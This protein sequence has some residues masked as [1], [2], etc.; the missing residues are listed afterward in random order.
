MALTCTAE[1]ASSTELRHLLPL[2]Q[3]AHLQLRQQQARPRRARASDFQA[4]RKLNP[5]G[6]RQSLDGS[7]GAMKDRPGSEHHQA[8][9]AMQ[10]PEGPPAQSATT[11]EIEDLERGHL[12][13]E[14]LQLHRLQPE[15]PRPIETIHM[16]TPRWA[17]LLFPRR[18]LVPCA[19]VHLSPWRHFPRRK[20]L[21]TSDL[22]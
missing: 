12:L 21:H 14:G 6:T 13:K 17:S 15:N 2:A 1:L 5:S 18:S 10:M 19:K 16:A 20:C 22:T 8:I 4:R 11:L 7:C 3:S 9:P